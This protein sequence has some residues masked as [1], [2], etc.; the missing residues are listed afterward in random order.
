[1]GQRSTRF[2]REFG[3]VCRLSA[4]LVQIFLHYQRPGA[5]ELETNEA[6]YNKTRFTIRRFFAASFLYDCHF[7]VIFFCDKI[8]LDKKMI[9]SA[10]GIAHDPAG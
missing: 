3:A 7:P 5:H 2:V 8:N 9:S 10:C 4:D 6:E 1:V